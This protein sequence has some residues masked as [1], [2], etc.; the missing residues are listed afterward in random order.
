VVFEW[1]GIGAWRV[2]RW[3]PTGKEVYPAHDIGGSLLGNEVVLLDVATG[4]MKS[5]YEAPERRTGLVLPAAKGN[6]VAFTQTGDMHSQNR[7]FCRNMR[8]NP[9]QV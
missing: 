2:A 8:Y 5:L 6:V 9:N 1:K 3:D 7:N 4:G